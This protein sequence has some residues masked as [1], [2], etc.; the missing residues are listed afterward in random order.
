MSALDRLMEKARRQGPCLLCGQG[1]ARHR[2]W[3]SIDAELRSGASVAKAAYWYGVDLQ[4][5]CDVR[6][7]YAAARRAKRQLPG[8]AI[9][10]TPPR[11]EGPYA[12]AR[13]TTGER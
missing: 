9:L 6:D 7:T 10:P 8:R 3:D 13:P 4:E 1:Y 11:I 12:P 5:V 2:L